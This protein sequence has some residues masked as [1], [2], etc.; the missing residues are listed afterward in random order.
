MVTL[1]NVIR[2]LI[3]SSGGCETIQRPAPTQISRK[4]RA[5][6]EQNRLSILGREQM[7]RWLRS[8][9]VASAAAMLFAA[10]PASGA[11][12]IKVGIMWPL[13]GNAGA[14]GLASKAAAE[15]AIDIINNAH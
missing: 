2:P 5:A 13:T 3:T 14:A 11:D 15:V 1:S 9:V 4:P 7:N 10:G 12:S 6:P 8:V